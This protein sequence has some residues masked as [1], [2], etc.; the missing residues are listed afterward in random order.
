MDTSKVPILEED[1]AKMRDEIFQLKEELKLLDWYIKI[2]ER[3]V[4]TRDII[5]KYAKLQ[6]E[7]DKYKVWAEKTIKD[8]K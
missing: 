2:L 5:E 1:N 8:F 7:F 4:D 6:D 3:G